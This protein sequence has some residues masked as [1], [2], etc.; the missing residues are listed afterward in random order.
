VNYGERKTFLVHPAGNMEL[1]HL[2]KCIHI[3]AKCTVVVR[4][5][6]FLPLIHRCFGRTGE[7][8][9]SQTTPMV[10]L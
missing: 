2:E 9:T 6:P 4:M 7:S 5:G 1:S 10:A 8:K 3:Y